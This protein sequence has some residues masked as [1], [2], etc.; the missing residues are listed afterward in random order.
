MYLRHCHKS[1]N[2]YQRIYKIIQIY[3]INRCVNC[4]H[5]HIRFNYCSKI[6]INLHDVCYLLKNKWKFNCLI[7]RKRKAILKLV[8]YFKLTLNFRCR[9]LNNN[10]LLN[11][12]CLILKV[13]MFIEY[14]S[15]MWIGDNLGPSIFYTFLHQW[16]WLFTLNEVFVL[17]FLVSF[18]TLKKT[19]WVIQE[20][21]H[22][23]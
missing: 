8:Y 19:A 1:W 4:A 9:N 21:W 18:E 20:V 3:T 6:R 7:T 16:R 10:M 12:H 14:S 2:N 11:E 23:F 13:F 5:V 17:T 15:K 22:I